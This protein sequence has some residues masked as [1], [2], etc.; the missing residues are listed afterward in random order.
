MY[1]QWWG[2]SLLNVPIQFILFFHIVTF[3]IGDKVELV[4]GFD[5]YGDASSGPL[6]LGD[7]GIVVDFQNGANGEMYVVA[8]FFKEIRLFLS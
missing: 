2:S 7:R 5:R 3:Q 6:Q 8:M 4:E 1:K